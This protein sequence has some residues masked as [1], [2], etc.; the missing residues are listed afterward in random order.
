MT[1]S[2]IPFFDYR[3][4]WAE[5][6][7]EFEQSLASVTSRGAYIMQY[8][9]EQFEYNLANYTGAKYAF[10]VADGTAALKIALICAG[11]K[12]LDEVIVSSHTFIAT[13][14]AVHDVGAIPVVADCTDSYTLDPDSIESL[15]TSRT[16]AIMP[17]QLNGR[18]AD[19]TRIVDIASANDLVIV[20]DSCQALGATYNSVHAGLFGEVGSFSFYPAK[21]LGCFGDGGA[22]ITNSLECSTLI[23]RLR[24]HGRDLSGQVATWG[25]NA[26]LDNIQAALLDIKLKHF[27]KTISHRRLL[28]T[29]YHNHLSSCPH[30]KLPPPPS[31]DGK[32]FDTFQNYE[33]QVERRQELRN[34]L[35][36]NGVS[37][38]IQW[39]GFM[40]HDFTHLGL[41]SSCPHARDMTPKYLLLP[42]HQFLSPSQVEY[43]AKLI[44]QFYSL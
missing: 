15:I 27:D 28:A 32:H 35:L 2:S 20:E 4:L 12:P 30:I 33:V 25:F 9:L 5:H 19:M 6:K 43:I 1:F 18:I 29:I 24:N 14:G 39:S 37:T 42:M 16:A 40:L 17:T 26:R 23:Q 31:S 10:G 21:T 38:I 7:L 36:E 8:E 34:F 41:R 13:A 3:A 44:C 22:V 11:V